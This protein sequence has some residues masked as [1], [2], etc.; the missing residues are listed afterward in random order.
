MKFCDTMDILEQIQKE[1]IN[2]HPQETGNLVQQALDQGIK[3]ERIVE[4]AMLSGVRIAGEGMKTDKFDLPRLLTAAKSVRIGFDVIEKRGAFRQETCGTVLLG[5]VEGDLHDVGK[6]LV[7]LMLKSQGIR[8]IDLGVDVSDKMFIKAVK[9]HPEID[10]V[11][12]SSLL[13]TS[14][15]GLVKVVKA[16]KKVPGRTYKIMVGGGAVT[17][18]IATNAGADAYTKD[19]IDAAIMAKQFLIQT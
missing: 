18:E 1:I 19:A 2:G 11:C 17:E 14:V 7:A 13:T 3:A 10:I 15:P 4:D 8:V 12:I 16:L 6:N 9:E 5:T